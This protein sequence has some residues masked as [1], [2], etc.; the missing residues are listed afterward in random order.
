MQADPP[1]LPQAMR[2]TLLLTRPAEQSARFAAAF[3][4]RFGPGWKIVLS[5][6]TELVAIQANLSLGGISTLIFTSETA[7]IVFSRQSHNRSLPCWCVGARTADAARRA[8][9]ADV[10]HGNGNTNDLVRE[11]IAVGVQGPCLHPR[12]V[13]SAG[14][15]KKV[16]D[17]AGIETHEVILYDQP[18]SP[19]TPQAR[20]LLAAPDPVLVPLFSPRAAALAAVEMQDRHCPLWLAA[21]SPAVAEAAAVLKADRLVTSVRPDVGAML[22]ALAQLISADRSA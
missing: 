11:M 18:S 2:P 8:G 4:D 6:L 15:L 5:P 21:F 22:D 17:S 13:H 10:R 14:D 19:L 3:G 16:L 7:V 1:L 9:F 12:G 20:G